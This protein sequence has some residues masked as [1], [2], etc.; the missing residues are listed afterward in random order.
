MLASLATYEL[1]RDSLPRGA[2]LHDLGT[3]RLR[4][5]TRPEQIFQL[6]APDLPADFAPLRTLDQHQ[7]NLPLQ[8]TALIGREH[9]V[10]QVCALLRGNE[11][12]LLT[13]TGPGGTGKTRL[14]LQ[15]A[16]EFLD[17][18][19][20]GVYFVALASIRDPALVIETIAATLGVKE[21]GDQPLLT[22]LKRHVRDKQL[23]L[24]LDNF[25]QVN[26]AAPQV[27]DLL[28]AVSR[29]KVLVT[30]RAGLQIYGEYEFP[31]PPLALPN[32]GHLPPLAQLIEYEAVRLFAERARAV[33]PDF[34][35]TNENA[36]AVAEICVRLDGLPLAIELAAVRVKV[37]TPPALL[38]RLS[39]RLQLLTGGARNLPARQQTLR[40][41]IAW[42]Y[43]LLPGYQQ[44]LFAQLAV[45]VGGCTVE[46]VE[47]ICTADGD[48]GVDIL[49]SLQ[50]LVN[51]SL[52]R[53]DVH[54][55][56]EPRLQMLE[57]IREYAQ[58][59]LAT[60]GEEPA[61]RARHATYYLGLAE[62]GQPKLDTEEQDIWLDR[63]EQEHDN[64]RAALAWVL[65]SRDGEVALRFGVALWHFWE[66]RGYLADWRGWVTAALGHTADA[67]APLGAA[68]YTAAGTMAYH[69]GEY[70]QAAIWH[71]H[72]LQ[73]YQSIGDLPGVAF[74][75]NNLGAQA[76][77][78][79]D[80]AK[81][82]QY[83]A[84][85]LALSQQLGHI[86]MSSSALNNMGI[87][88]RHQGNY[89]RAADLLT[90]ALALAR[91]SGDQW[92]ICN[93]LIELAKVA[94]YQGNQ[95]HAVT[96]NAEA[97]TLCQE[98]HQP[99]PIA[100]CLE[101]LACSALRCGQFTRAVRLF[102]A[103]EQLRE[104]IGVPLPRVEQQRYAEVTL[105][106]RTAL[107]PAAYERAW[108]EGRR[109]PL[110][111]AIAYAL[112]GDES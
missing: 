95:A 88:A 34:A 37:L 5:L 36:R 111:E 72:A 8:P 55:S 68:A 39:R 67:S 54:P 9:E 71:W 69:Q 24:V 93:E 32:L 62:A 13:L 3:H 76:E 101:G 46:A 53:Q 103:A 100:E 84:E 92:Y 108:L 74:A 86:R 82:M 80:F 40:D 45:F 41:T 94:W 4:D 106:A 77:R 26:D 11:T 66:M 31:V 22:L 52:V 81:A 56:A 99:E 28:S 73:L 1:V 19:A 44:A 47:A 20:D 50:A 60:R 33:K 58:E 61:L 107:E 63:L 21:G 65:E 89:D 110:D 57:T 27:A 98:I 91:A 97:L 102:G 15:I 38:A 105:L 64:L 79:R 18:F 14:A 10:A 78:Q 104:V 48:A 12:R 17:S 90:Q 75:L 85:S 25:E 87:V 112:N 96:L 109:M 6:G 2:V 42:I 23:L 29:L 51:N 59:Q 83:L 49:D 35:I 30:S 70:A 7:T 43:D 16:A